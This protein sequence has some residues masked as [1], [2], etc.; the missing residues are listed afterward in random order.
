VHRRRVRVC[1]Q[2]PLLVTVSGLSALV[3]VAGTVH[4]RFAE[5]ASAG[6]AIRTAFAIAILAIV[7]IAASG[8]VRRRHP[9]RR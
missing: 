4:P 9:R 8:S 6:A 1:R 3:V 5:V 7:L 2:R